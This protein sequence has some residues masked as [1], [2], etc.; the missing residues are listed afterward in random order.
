MPLFISFIYYCYI[1]WNYG[2]IYIPFRKY[3]WYSWNIN[4]KLNVSMS[5][6]DHLISFYIIPEYLKRVWFRTLPLLPRQTLRFLQTAYRNY[7][8][9]ARHLPEF[10]GLLFITPA[11][12]EYRRRV[13]LFCRV[14]GRFVDY[15]WRWCWCGGAGWVG[16]WWRN[17]LA[18]FA[19]LAP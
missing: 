10:F 2:K 3:R 15:R 16:C 1:E 17:R 18:N 8:R 5:I 9:I 19:G 14:G 11:R 4:F 12:T 13:N 6:V 7:I